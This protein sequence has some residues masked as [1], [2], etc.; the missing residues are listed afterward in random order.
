M[1]MTI[2]QKM[3]GDMM[4]HR[5]KNGA[6]IG[7]TGTEM[8]MKMIITATMMMEISGISIVYKFS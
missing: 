1:T 5:R 2:I 6:K 8:K 4:A 7:K 3:A